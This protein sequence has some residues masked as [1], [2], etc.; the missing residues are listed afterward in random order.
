VCAGK[1][2]AEQKKTITLA[3]VINSARMTLTENGEQ[4]PDDFGYSANTVPDDLGGLV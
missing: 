1:K 4:Y 2:L 3:T